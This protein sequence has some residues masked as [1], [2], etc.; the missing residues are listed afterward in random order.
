MTFRRLITRAV[1][2]LICV[3]FAVTASRAEVPLTLSGQAAEGGLMF[4][5]TN[6]GAT[7]A[8]DGVPVSVSPDGHFLLGFGRDSTWRGND[9]PRHCCTGS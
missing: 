9:D 8:L 5:K 3:T 2:A 6:P 7:V 1:L 4:G